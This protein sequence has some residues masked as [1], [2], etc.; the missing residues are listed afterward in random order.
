MPP[1]DSHWLPC[2]RTIAQ[3][4]G[5]LL[6]CETQERGPQNPASAHCG[7]F[8]AQIPLERQLTNPTLTALPSSLSQEELVLPW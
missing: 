6:G 2:L 4:I 1:G 7:V 8:L 3:T 5:T